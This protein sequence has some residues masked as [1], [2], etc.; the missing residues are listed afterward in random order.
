MKQNDR[1]MELYK[2]APDWESADESCSAT[3]LNSPEFAGEVKNQQIT[4]KK[5]D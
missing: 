3:P 4:A 1:T 5:H 2:P